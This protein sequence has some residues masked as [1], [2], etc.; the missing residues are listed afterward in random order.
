[1]NTRN[2]EKRYRM[3][4]YNEVGQAEGFA[5]NIFECYK[6]RPLGVVHGYNFNTMSLMTFAMLFE[7]YFLIRSENSIEIKTLTKKR[8]QEREGN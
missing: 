6:I 5:A 8:Q 2:P 1:M 4:K 7:P 3:I